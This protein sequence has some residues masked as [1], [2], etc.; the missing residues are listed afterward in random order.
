MRLLCLELTPTRTGQGGGH[1]QSEEATPMSLVSLRN[2]PGRKFKAGGDSRNNGQGRPTSS[3]L[4]SW[5]L[6]FHGTVIWP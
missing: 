2:S 4:R 6:G 3:L 5:P 1:P